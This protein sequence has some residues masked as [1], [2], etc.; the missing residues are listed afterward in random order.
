MAVGIYNS[1]EVSITFAT[2]P[3]TDNRAPD[4]F[5]TIEPMVPERHTMTVGADGEVTYSQSNDN[6]HKATVKVLQSSE[7][8]AVLSAI[9]K[10][11]LKTPGG[12]GVGPFSAIDANGTSLCVDPEARIQGWPTKTYGQLA[13]KVQE[14]VILLPDPERFDGEI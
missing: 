10:G 8:N 3:I 14:W 2:I 1:N 11:D 9:L 4:D 7:A 5:L 6:T 13:D 12:A